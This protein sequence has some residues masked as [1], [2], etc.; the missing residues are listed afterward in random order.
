MKCTSCGGRLEGTMTFCPFC[1]VR[2][3]VNLRQIHFR[4]LGT[5][6]SMPCPQCEIPLDVIEFDS[7]PKLKV[8]RC[9][10]CLGMFF[11][12]GEIEAL[13]ESQTNPLVWIDTAQLT[14]I[15]AD[16]GSGHRVI[17]RKCPMCAERMSHL[18]FGGQSGVILDRC[19]KHGVWVE[20]SELR[21]LMEWWRAG[22]KHIHQQRE[23]QKAKQ[24]Y[25][26]GGAIE[27]AV[28]MSGSL[29]PEQENSWDKVE[30]GLSV[31]YVIGALAVQIFK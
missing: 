16:F 14:R 12:P 6:A 9:N 15:V 17:Y 25:A 10:K 7:E 21:R 23:A 11:N 3:D 29:E 13:L 27:A 1:G 31:A 4:D 26:S 30:K 22:G 20:G 18:N 8:E 19:G 28:S 2:Q 5:D 24:L